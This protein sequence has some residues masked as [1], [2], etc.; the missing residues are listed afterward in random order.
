M[1]RSSERRRHQR[2]ELESPLRGSIGR[3]PVD[4]IDVSV[5]GICVQHRDPLPHVGTACVLQFTAPSGTIRV[6]CN[7]SRSKLFRCDKNGPLF[8][9][10]LRIDRADE[11]S[12][13]AVRAMVS[14]FVER[15][16]EEQ[17]A[18]AHGEPPPLTRLQAASA[19]ISGFLRVERVAGH[20]ERR[21]T[22]EQRQPAHGFTISAAEKN[23][24]VALLC[25]A[26]DRTT[27]EGK[28]LIQ[29]LAELSIR[30]DEGGVVRRY[31][32]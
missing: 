26:Y 32:P 28:R 3:T 21:R 23:E 14:F 25:D 31:E 11:S 18:N 29:I 12:L 2:V 15:A 17:K 5:L 22:K 1:F 10:G 7:V 8:H 19:K 4:V 24:S 30:P 9:T 20:W 27:A 13:E 6:Q 16:L